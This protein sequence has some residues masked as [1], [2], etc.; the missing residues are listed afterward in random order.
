MI[1]H[2]NVVVWVLMSDMGIFLGVYGDEEEA[3]D[4]SREFESVWGENKVVMNE[5]ML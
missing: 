5:V 2:A 4:A 1:L 3:R